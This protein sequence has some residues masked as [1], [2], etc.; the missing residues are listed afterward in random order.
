MRVLA[1]L[2]VGWIALLYLP[3]IMSAESSTVQNDGERILKNVENA[4]K[5]VKD[6][7]VDLDVTANI[8]RMNIPPMHARMF[9]RQP[10]KFHYESENFA[11]LPREGLAFSVSRLLSRF[12]VEEVK[13]ENS[14]QGKQFRLQLRPKDQRAKTMELQVTIDSARWRPM[15]I[16]SSLF[17]GRTMSATFQYEKYDGFLLPSL[18]TVH[19]TAPPADT[20]VQRPDLDEVG[21]M[22]RS[23]VPRVGTITIRYSEYK[24]N[25]G[26]SDEVF[27][28]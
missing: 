24:V 21:P 8:E 22:T 16:V 25:T 19:F 11:L 2:I 7:T 26:L 14:G 4:L 13:E 23:Q 1:Q 28:K 12:S 5:E 10:D 17:D 9:Y 18:L 20:T 27:E 15:R 3:L 6:F